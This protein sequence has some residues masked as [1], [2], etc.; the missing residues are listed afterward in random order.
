[1][2][3]VCVVPAA[4]AAAAE[5]AHLQSTA[6]GKELRGR[7][8]RRRV[9]PGVYMHVGECFCGWVGGEEGVMD[10]QPAPL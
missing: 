7:K 8:R 3:R 9:G 5:K 10:Q 6:Q 4:A 2:T 1:M